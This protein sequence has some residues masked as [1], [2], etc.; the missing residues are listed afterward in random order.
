MFAPAVVSAVADEASVR[1]LPEVREFA[2]I[3]T[4]FPVVVVDVND[5]IPS[6]TVRF[7]PVETRVSPFSDTVPVPVESVF[8]PV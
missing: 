7:F 1:P 4:A 8:A 6:E 5:V 3:L 2:L